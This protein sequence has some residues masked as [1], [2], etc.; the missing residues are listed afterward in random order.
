[1][2]G[3]S[4]AARHARRQHGH[5]LDWSPPGAAPS[6]APAPAPAALTAGGHCVA[7]LL[8]GAALAEGID[9]HGQ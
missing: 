4:C 7:A 3:H 1:M 2:R 9:E 5:T 8:E 6:A